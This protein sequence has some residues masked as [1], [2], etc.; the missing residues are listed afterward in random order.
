MKLFNL[1]NYE[2]LHPEW[3]LLIPLFVI[4]HLLLHIYKSKG[5]RRATQASLSDPL[6]KQ[7]HLFH[8]LIQTL[9]LNNPSHGS[10]RSHG[11]IYSLMLVAFILALTHPVRIGEKLPDP[12]QERDIIFIV[13]A[14]VSMILRDYILNGERIDRMSM[15]KGVLDNFISQLKGER[16][17]IIVFGDHAYTLVPLT[18]D[19]SLL[20]R[21]LLRIE[22]TIAGRFNAMGEGIA[23]AV[24]QASTQ[25]NL[26]NKRKTTLVLLTDADL[27]T[28]KFDPVAAAKM[29]KTQNLALYTIAIGSTSYAAEE[30]RTT[31]LIYAPVDLELIKTLSSITGAM[32]YQAGTPQALENAIQS[33][34]KHDTNIK[35]IKPVYYRESLYHYLLLTVF[36]VFTIH[37]LILI[38]IPSQPIHKDKNI[39]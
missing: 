4:L 1:Q 2:L 5:L 36:I 12:P 6:S 21:M 35:D 19:E 38:V 23:L 29:A 15:L 28:G 16:M 26:K 3:L 34:R 37:Q 39:D 22:S 24:K 9:T 18:S 14:S 10:G 31:G 33:I 25:N 7:Q 8:P 20:R 27:P 13:D 11:L 32:S 17:S 30:I